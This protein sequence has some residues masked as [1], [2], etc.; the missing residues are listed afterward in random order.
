MERGRF[1]KKTQE[2][3]EGPADVCGMG[4]GHTEEQMDTRVRMHGPLSDRLRE[5][6]PWEQTRL[7]SS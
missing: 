4:T 6:P 2:G 3:A 7:E 5:L 1:S